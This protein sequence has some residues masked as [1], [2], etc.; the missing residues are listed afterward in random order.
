MVM[1]LPRDYTEVWKI[2]VVIQDIFTEVCRRARKK[3]LMGS[4]VTSI[5]SLKKAKVS[6]RSIQ[7][8]F[9]YFGILCS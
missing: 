3:G 8:T 1:T 7:L 4:I 6:K 5:I 9:I 2:E